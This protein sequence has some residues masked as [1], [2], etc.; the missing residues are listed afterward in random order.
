M[1]VDWIR[2]AD[3]VQLALENSR[4]GDPE[5]GTSGLEVEFN[6]LD[7]DLAPVAHVGYGPERLMYLR[8]SPL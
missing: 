6:I 2:F 4:Q 5:S 7:A 8:I 3:K 1:T